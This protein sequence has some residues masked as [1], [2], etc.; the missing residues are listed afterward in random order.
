[1]QLKIEPWAEEKKLDLNKPHIPRSVYSRVVAVNNRF[2]IFENLGPSN[3][4]CVKVVDPCLHILVDIKLYAFANEN[5]P[6]VARINYSIAACK[7]K[8]FI[9]GGLNVD[10]NTVVDTMESFDIATYQ[11]TAIKQR[12]DLKPIGRQGHTAIVIDKYTMLVFGGTS[13]S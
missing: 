12:G 9:Y 13:E 5:K 4:N 3:F 11:F 8:V 10:T 2:Y 6:N 7:T 1:M